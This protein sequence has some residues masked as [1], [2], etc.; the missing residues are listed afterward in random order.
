[1]PQSYSIFLMLQKAIMHIP[2]IPVVKGLLTDTHTRCEHY[3]SPLDIIAIK[4]KCCNTYYACIQCHEAIAGHPA[5]VWRKNEFYTKAI[6]CGNCNY[7][8][9]IDE[10]LHSDYICPDCKSPLNPKCSNHNHFYF[11]EG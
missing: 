9:S 5:E 10:Y 11:E 7:E 4:M 8:M 1:M 2:E 6:L 3:N